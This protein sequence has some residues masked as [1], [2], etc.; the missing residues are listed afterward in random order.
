VHK[1]R[2]T[3]GALASQGRPDPALAAILFRANVRDNP[4]RRPPGC[5][6][7]PYTDGGRLPV[8][9]GDV[10]QIRGIPDRDDINGSC[11]Y[12]LPADIQPPAGRLAV[13]LL[14]GGVPLAVPK[15]CVYHIWDAVGDHPLHTTLAK[16]KSTNA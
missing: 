5:T 12:M 1:R 14:H 9:P 3:Q 10:I 4:T 6:A 7:R 16:W 2:T 11:G 15:T 13:R 8:Q